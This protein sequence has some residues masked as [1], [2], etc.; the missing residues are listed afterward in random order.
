M[1]SI[2]EQ[3]EIKSRPDFN[4]TGLWEINEKNANCPEKARL[5]LCEIYEKFIWLL[6]RKIACLTKEEKISWPRDS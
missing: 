5:M 1:F 4:W 2:S 6:T 3:S